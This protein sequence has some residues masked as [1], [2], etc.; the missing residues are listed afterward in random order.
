MNPVLSSSSFFF[1]CDAQEDLAACD[2]PPT[3]RLV[4]SVMFAADRGESLPVSIANFRKVFVG[5]QAA[6]SVP[7]ATQVTIVNRLIT[8]LG[9]LV[10]RN[11]GAATTHLIT[12]RALNDHYSSAVKRGIPRVKPDWVIECFRRGEKVACDRFEV[13]CFAGAY[14]HLFGLGEQANEIQIKVAEH[15]GVCTVGGDDGQDEGE[16]DG[17]MAEASAAPPAVPLLTTHVIVNNAATKVTLPFEIAELENVPIVH[18]SWVDEVLNS[19]GTRWATKQHE[20]ADAAVSGA[21]VAAPI[22]AVQQIHGSLIP[23]IGPRDTSSLMQWIE[24]ARTPAAVNADQHIPRIAHFSDI[25]ELQPAWLGRAVASVDLTV[26]RS[27]I[28]VLA[29]ALDINEAYA[30]T[31]RAV[32]A[33]RIVVGIVLKKEESLTSEEILKACSNPVTCGSIFNILTAYWNIIKPGKKYQLSLRAKF[34]L[35]ALQLS[36]VDVAQFNQVSRAARC[37]L[38]V[39]ALLLPPLTPF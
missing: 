13:G 35:F 11:V 5:C 8:T 20:I 24:T 25:M 27:C 33:A 29:R 30:D 38:S 23:P 19:K 14:L 4:S 12:S 31:L 28:T 37:C 39:A 7:D 6:V 17:E 1:V 18:R 26:A 15:G 34:S 9:G 22:T 3:A 16:D 32:M 2:L 36:V 21:A 10:H